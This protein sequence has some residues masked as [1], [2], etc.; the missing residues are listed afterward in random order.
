MI[1]I[2]YI[3]SPFN[4][5]T[6][7]TFIILPHEVKSHLIVKDFQPILLVM[8]IYLFIYLLLIY[9]TMP[10]NPECV[11]VAALLKYNISPSISHPDTRLK[12]GSMC[13]C[14]RFKTERCSRTMFLKKV[15]TLSS[16]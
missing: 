13:R 12:H 16:L 9:L 6:I 8:C 11:I 10:S 1:E 2:Y 14:F 15:P 5:I 4:K 3:V 7:A